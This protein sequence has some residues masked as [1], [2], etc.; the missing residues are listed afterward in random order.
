MLLALCSK[1][2][3][4]AVLHLPKG[5]IPLESR[6]E[7]VENSAEVW[8][9]ALRKSQ[10]LIKTIYCLCALYFSEKTEKRGNFFF[11][12]Y[13]VSRFRLLTVR[14][15]NAKMREMHS[16]FHRFGSAFAIQ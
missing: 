14:A 6:C 11:K 12:I 9:N 8:E 1:S 13:A 7:Q 4:D 15:F 2:R 10:I 5:S 16:D 3:Q